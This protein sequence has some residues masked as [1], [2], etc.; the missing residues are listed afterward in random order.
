MRFEFRFT[1]EA[2]DARPARRE[3]APLR[4]LVMGDLSGRAG[5]AD[6]GTA[7]PLVDRPLMPVD[8]EKLG[9][10]FARCAP[11][12]RIR[13][14]G[15]QG[16]ELAI[17]VGALDEFHPDALFQ[18]L[19]LFAAFRETR[20]RLE[21]PATFKAAAADLGGGAPVPVAAAGADSEEDAET[22]RRLLGSAPGDLTQV[23]I[24]GRLREDVRR[25]VREMVAPYVVAEADPRQAELVASIDR[26]I[27]EQ[28]RALLHHPA[29]QALEATWRSVERLVTA[30]ETGAEIEVFLLDALRDE[31]EADVTAAGADLERSQLHRLL[32]ERGGALPGAAAWGLIVGA[33][34][35]GPDAGDVALLAALGAV[36]SRAGGPFIAAAS[37]EVLG[38]RSLAETPD[39]REWAAPAAEAA[40]RWTALRAS[41]WARWIG[42]AAPRVLLRLPYGART[43]P[44]E[45]FAFEE[46][47]PGRDHEAY[48]WG[49]PAFACAT[50]L[51]MS[52]AERGWAMQPGDHLELGGLPAHAYREGEES[53]LEPC[54][55]ALLTERALESILGRGVMPLMS[56]PDRNA[57]RVVRFHSLAEPPSA[58]AGAWG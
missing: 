54:A 58:L 5:R 30:V 45:R 8:H 14:G 22:I 23:K 47:G 11:G 44:T 28:M 34:S 7:G 36:A 10:V 33:Y 18:R 42:L 2:P 57:V 12:L 48:L 37:P 41:P 31:L 16:P 19:G 32:V 46:L 27:G 55:E 50:L 9:K 24:E 6:A 39:P 53:R 21:N 29:F 17:A 13:L 49:N 26:A 15:S 38:C 40:A 35:F 1:R 3:T 56:F 20:Q 25:A 43:E 52:F 51:A 4:I